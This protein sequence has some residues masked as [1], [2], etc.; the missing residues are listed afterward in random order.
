MGQ[1]LVYTIGRY[2]HD[3]FKSGDPI[4]HKQIVMCFPSP[5]FLTSNGIVNMNLIINSSPKGNWS[6]SFDEVE[7]QFLRE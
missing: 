2:A 7:I 3:I 1:L 5:P 4:C 6:A